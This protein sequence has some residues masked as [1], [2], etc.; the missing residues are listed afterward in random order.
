MRAAGGDADLFGQLVDGRMDLVEIAECFV[1]ALRVF[2]FCLG[3]SADRVGFDR[4]DHDVAGGVLEA[5][6][7]DHCN[8][9]AA[10]FQLETAQPVRQIFGQAV[11][12]NPM[13]EHRLVQVILDLL[14]QLMLAA[15]HAEN[16]LGIPLDRIDQRVIGRRIAGV[17]CHHHIRVVAGIVCNVTFEELQL[18][19]SEVSG[20]PIAEVDDV[21]L[22][23]QPDDL[24]VAALA[25]LEIVVDR[26]G[27]IRL[28]A[29][30]VDDAQRAVLRQSRENIFDDF[31]ITVDLAEFRVRLREN[32]SLR[33][34]DAETNQKVAGRTVRNQIVLLAVVRKHSR[35]RRVGSGCTL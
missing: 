9:V 35:Y 5:G 11:L 23:V 22:E 31:K 10:G 32:L 7:F 21:V 1:L 15:R 29:A 17:Q 14:E 18:A 3:G 30:K 24:Y 13:L 2:F 19:V 34:H 4:F 28:A 33:A 6:K 26:K 27:Q 25:Q 8:M 12:E 16:D 20:D